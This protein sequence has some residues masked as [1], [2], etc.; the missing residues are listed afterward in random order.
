MHRWL[1]LLVVVACESREKEAPE[2]GP[3]DRPVPEWKLTRDEWNTVVVEM[4]RG[5]YDE[6]TR[7][8]DAAAPALAAQIEASRAKPKSMTIRKPH[9]AGDDDLTRGQARARWALPV[10]A[11]A[12]VV[13]LDSAKI[14]AV[15]VRVGDR[16]KAIVGVDQIVIDHTRALDADCARYLEELGTKSCQRLGWAI[17]EAALQVDKARL[18]RMCALTD[19]QCRTYE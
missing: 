18:A 3:L 19:S 12:E 15:F 7:A 17:A 5:T 13:W 1:V 4:F 8:F 14:D 2:S 10:Q 11:P 6:Y 9:F 16:Y